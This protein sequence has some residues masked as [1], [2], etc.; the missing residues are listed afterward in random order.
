MYTLYCIWTYPSFPHLFTVLYSILCFLIFLL[1]KV[2]FGKLDTQVS[3]FY[4]KIILQSR[5]M[6]YSQPKNTSF[7]RYMYLVIKKKTLYASLVF[8]TLKIHLYDPSINIVRPGKIR[9]Y[10]PGLS[11]YWKKTKN[12]VWRNKKGQ[13]FNT[14]IKNRNQAE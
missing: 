14:Y 8:K 9:K 10:C 2:L 4:Y 11:H 13:T 5:L 12:I 3:K 1:L 7:C 6:K